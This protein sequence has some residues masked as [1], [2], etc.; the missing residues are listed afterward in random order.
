MTDVDSQLK[1]LGN[2]IDTLVAAQQELKNERRELQQ[3]LSKYKLELG[4]REQELQKVKHELKQAHLARG[5][6]AQDGDAAQAKAKL[7]SL[8]REIDRCI[9]LLNE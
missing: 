1:K 2:L 5:L 9:A 4:Q 6:T 8:M 3:E 7:S